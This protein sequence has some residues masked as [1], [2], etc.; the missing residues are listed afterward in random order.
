MIEKVKQLVKGESE[1]YYKWHISL[2]SDHA[3]RLADIYTE[4]DKE[5]VELAAL[6]HDIARIRYE[7]KD[8]EIKALPEIEKILTDLSCPIEK[9]DAVKHCALTHRG[10]KEN[11]PE[12]IE[13]KIIANADAMAH[14]DSALRFFHK[15][16]SRGKDYE[17]TLE[18]VSNKLQRDWDNKL[19]LPEAREM[20]KD[21]Y[22]AIKLLL[23][24][25]K[26]VL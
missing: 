4:A 25:A 23:G 17:D 1:Y 6:L 14:F 26:K 7:N 15:E 24:S 9:I 18:F 11:Q 13:A 5:V 12:T 22:D 21:K 3:L 10:K 2:V 8:H 16:G 20:V 19:T